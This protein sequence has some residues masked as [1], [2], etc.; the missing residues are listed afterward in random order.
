MLLTLELSLYLCFMG[1]LP[2]D[3]AHFMFVTQFMVTL[4]KSELTT[5]RSTITFLCLSPAVA[6]YG[7]NLIHFENV[8]RP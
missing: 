8:L 6:I 2:G 3:N 5:S 7:R 4:D 1:A